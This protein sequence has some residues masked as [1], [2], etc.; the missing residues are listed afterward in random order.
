MK[1]I[2]LTG[3][4]CLAAVLAGCTTS[5]KVQEMIDASHQDYS[6]R[7]DGHQD[8]IN[9]LKQSAMKGLEKSKTNADAVAELQVDLQ[10]IRAKLQ[11][12][13]DSAEAS[14]IMSAANT[15][16]MS[17]L[18]S[19]VAENHRQVDETV[20]RLAEIDKLFENVMLRH[21][22]MIVQSANEAMSS[23]KAESLPAEAA[24][25]VKL[26]EPIE[27][28]APDTSVPVSSNAPSN[29]NP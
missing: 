21:Y 24:T 19:A 23:L 12:L 11:E 29:S 15:V 26:D 18:E 17:E 2:Y 14:K 4:V 20:A 7:L 10:A 27:I 25:P 28:I 22:E 9:V 16:K 8:S 1:K 13:K 5:S 6:V 3:A